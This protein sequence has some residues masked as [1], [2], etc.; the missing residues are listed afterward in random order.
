MLRIN[1]GGTTSWL[2]R[3]PLRIQLQA[4]ALPGEIY[5]S[6]LSIFIRSSPNLEAPVEARYYSRFG[7]MTTKV[8]PTSFQEKDP[9]PLEEAQLDVP[10]LENPQKGRWERSWPTIACGAGLFSDGYLN[11]VCVPSC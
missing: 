6:Y 7:T 1:S 11:G 10:P 8:E 4:V 5:Y 2:L 9:A 3:L